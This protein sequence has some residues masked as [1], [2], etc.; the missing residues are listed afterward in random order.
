MLFECRDE[1]TKGR[2]LCRFNSEL[3]RQ[4]ALPQADLSSLAGSR[5]SQSQRSK[6][7]QS[8]AA[9]SSTLQQ[10]ETV[11]HDENMG[12]EGFDALPDRD[13]AVAEAILGSCWEMCPGEHSFKSI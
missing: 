8:A 6:A 13:C 12:Y 1:E 9:E 11:N 7:L 5:N 2:R 10:G 4:P 3:N